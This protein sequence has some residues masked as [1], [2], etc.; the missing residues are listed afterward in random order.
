MELAWKEIVIVVAGSSGLIG[1]LVS[2]FAFVTGRL[3]KRRER[4]L[5]HASMSTDL[6]RVK[7]EEERLDEW[8]WEG[9]AK[10][11]EAQ[12]LVLKQE[13]K[14]EREA[15]RQTKSTARATLD[16]LAEMFKRLRVAKIPDEVVDILSEK[17]ERAVNAIKKGRDALG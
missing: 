13:L 6:R 11:K 15:H 4:D 3:D 8:I 12:I 7:L 2:A 5:M 1:G 9:V 14:D 16:E 17:I 10:E